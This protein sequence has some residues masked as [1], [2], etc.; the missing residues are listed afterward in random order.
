LVHGRI[1]LL[2][3]DGKWEVAAWG[4][5]LTDEEYDQERFF[6]DFIGMVSA[7]QGTPRQYGMTF[8]YNL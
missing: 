1:S 4:K 6:S 8:N 2:S 7:G 5:N 3:N